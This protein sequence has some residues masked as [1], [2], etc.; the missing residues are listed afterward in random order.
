MKS[1]PSVCAANI[2]LPYIPLAEP[3][4]ATDPQTAQQWQMTIHEAIRVALSNSEAVRRLGLV[5]AGSDIDII[6]SE[7]TVYDPLA[8]DAA[9]DAEWGIFDPV[10]TTSSQWNK[11]DVPPGTSFGGIGN[12]PP[13]LDLADF[14]S[15]VEQ[16]FPSG[17]QFTMAYV[18]DYLFNP[19]SGSVID[20]NPQYFNYTQFG[21]V[22]PL[23]QG[24]GVAYT[25]APIRIAAAQAEQTDW[26]F[27]QEMLALVR[28]VETTYWA[29]YAQQQNLKVIE[30]VLPVYREI[31]RVREEQSSADAG[32]K[33][34][35]SRARA[36]YYRF[37]QRR[38]QTMSQIAEQQ[39]VLR[40]LLGLQ[41]NDG[42]YI[43]LVAM[44]RSTPPIET[45]ADAVNTAVNRRPSVLRQR[46]QVYV[47][48][49]ETVIARSLFRPQLDFNAFWQMNGLDSEIGPAMQQIA[50]DDYNSWNMGF[51]FSIPLG[52][53]EARANLRAKQ[54]EIS[55]ARAM[56]NQE[57][58][59]TAFEVADAY[60]RIQ[61]LEPQRQIAVERVTA[62]NEWQEGAKAQ[63]ENPPPGMSSVFAMELYL[64]NLRDIV[65]ATESSNAIIADYNSA[66]ARLE[67]V[68]GTLLD[69]RLVEVEGD[70]TGDVPN[71][72]PM[73][74]IKFT[75]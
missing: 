66:F 67:E 4:L 23:M 3:G 24:F 58:H 71:D 60:R 52:R 6:S 18:N 33:L 53:R 22:Q 57:A 69:S 49:Q 12:I 72:L 36:D 32:S 68:K 62:L 27:K 42:R 74:E 46:L 7:I 1:C 51:T 9:A 59:Q 5:D 44:P 20:P 2:P 37:E 35:L 65:E 15:G 8:A 14:Y 64:Q 25:M 63:F 61:M 17:G 47:A 19:F 11:Q 16:L 54:Y 34:E 40:D 56:L 21:V 29:L 75:E 41:P 10:W 30:Q 55:S 31:V 43:V 39:L 73:P 45:V 70:A 13:R 50:D 26:Q 38:L 48:Q 28:S